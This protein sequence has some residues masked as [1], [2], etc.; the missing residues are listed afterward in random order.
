[1]KQRNDS[2]SG[3]VPK[4]KMNSKSG[5]RIFLKQIQATAF[6]STTNMAKINTKT[7]NKHESTNANN[8]KPVKCANKNK[9]RVCAVTRESLVRKIAQDQTKK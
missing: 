6:K 8:A 2:S 4:L 1:M 3:M 5:E 7:M 9:K